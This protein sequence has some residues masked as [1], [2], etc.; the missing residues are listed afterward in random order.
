MGYP[1]PQESDTLLTR[2]D[3]ARI[4]RVSPFTLARWTSRG[5]GPPWIKL[6]SRRVVYRSGDVRAWLKNQKGGPG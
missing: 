3:L 5:E 4:L 1:L 2:G 6:G